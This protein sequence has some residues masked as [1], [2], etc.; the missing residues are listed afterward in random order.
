MRLERRHWLTLVLIAQLGWQGRAGAQ[1]VA[2]AASETVPQ[3]AT[4]SR[5]PVADPGAPP[6]TPTVPPAAPT[7]PAASEAPPAAATPH[8]ASAAP[9]P[10]LRPYAPAVLHVVPVTNAGPP[11]AAA[12]DCSGAVDAHIKD[13]EEKSRW[14]RGPALQLSVGGGVG[15]V[16]MDGFAR[17]IDYFAEEEPSTNES[18]RASLWQV[19]AHLPLGDFAIGVSY[20]GVGG[21]E[22]GKPRNL[23][24]LMGEFI[25]QC[26][27]VG[28]RYTSRSATRLGRDLRHDAW[29]LGGTSSSLWR[30]HKGLFAGFD[31]GTTLIFRSPR[32]NEITGVDDPMAIAFELHGAIV[33]GHAFY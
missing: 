32:R 11:A 18:F 26:A 33:L 29:A 2:P 15:Y 5:P 19:G 28:S 23:S 4:E 20:L 27:C 21:E 12:A 16:L 6:E 14:A 1:A 30:I 31:L 8:A 22:A 7:P 25:R 24:L 13:Q 17:D 10:V 9:S 3:P